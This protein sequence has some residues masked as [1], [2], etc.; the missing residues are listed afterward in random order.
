MFE[1][2]GNKRNWIRRGLG[3]AVMGIVAAGVLG[4]VVMS[5]WNG[6]MPPLFGL[7]AL[8]FWQAVGLLILARILFG[9]FGRG[10]HGGH[11]RHRQRMIQRWEAMTPEERESFKHGFRGR[12]RGCGEKAAPA[13]NES[14]H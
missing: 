2:P 6:L 1:H 9:G 14:G 3:I 5:L 8:H 13:G 10:H 12:F 11:F 4:W 7:K